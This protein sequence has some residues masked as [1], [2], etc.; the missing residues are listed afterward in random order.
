MAKMK[1][2][3]LNILKDS[4]EVFDYQDFIEHYFDPMQITNWKKKK[5]KELAEE[6]MDIIL[7]FLIWCDEFPE[8]VQT[9]EV[10]REFQNEF[11]ERIFVHC[12][13]NSYLDSYVPLFIQRLIEVTLDHKDEEYYTSVERAAIVACNES[14]TVYATDEMETAKILGLKYKEWKTELDSRVRPTHIVMEGVKIPIDEPFLVGN[15]LMM[16][17]KDQTYNPEPEE[18]CGCRCVC[19]YS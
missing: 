6:L 5:R 13:P 12:E 1:I 9:E 18:V 4:T 16:F 15:S 3:E 8:Q 10:Q 14:N 11:K 17:P 2:D 7:Y 19:K